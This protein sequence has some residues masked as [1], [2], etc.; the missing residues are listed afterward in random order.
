M[1]ITGKSLT[2]GAWLVLIAFVAILTTGLLPVVI[3]GLLVG[4]ILLLVYFAGVRVYRRGTG[5]AK[6]STTQVEFK[7]GYEEDHGE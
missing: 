5:E 4:L 3:A 7:D 2:F 1:R 6:S